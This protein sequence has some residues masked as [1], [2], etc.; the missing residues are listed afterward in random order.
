[1]R[2][3]LALLPLVALSG[4]SKVISPV[5]KVGLDPDPVDKLRL[6]GL[7]IVL[8]APAFVI[9]EKPSDSGPMS[10]TLSVVNRPDPVHAYLVDIKP[11][12]MSTSDYSLTYGP[13]GQVAAIGITQT[14]AASSLIKPIGDFVAGAVSIVAKVVGA[15]AMADPA[16]P[17]LKHGLRD[18]LDEGAH[19]PDA[20]Y[21]ETAVKEFKGPKPLLELAQKAVKRCD[22]DALAAL[23]CPECKKLLGAAEGQVRCNAV[24][25]VKAR[26]RPDLDDAQNAAL[27][28][29]QSSGE[30][31]LFLAAAGA[32]AGFNPDP[33]QQ[34]LGTADAGVAQAV[35]KAVEA[36]MPDA[37][38]AVVCSNCDKL[39]KLA[40]EVIAQRQFD[41]PLTAAAKVSPT[42]WRNRHAARLEWNID[43]VE[44]QLAL[45]PPAD[46]DRKLR[47]Q[48]EALQN[49]LATT[50]GASD[51][52]ARMRVL[53]AVLER[54]PEDII[55]K[56]SKASNVAGMTEF[57]I[58]SKELDALA[59][60][61]AA[62]RQ[63][64]KLAPP[65]APPKPVERTFSVT[66]SWKKGG[67]ADAA[68]AKREADQHGKPDFIVTVEEG[69]QP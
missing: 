29:P 1:M 4:C 65:P 24:P 45:G 44:E 38:A 21:Y 27:L 40:T 13:Q 68:Y 20:S 14:S 32:A 56:L 55:P 54:K 26:L 42:E 28:Y 67:P 17:L 8:T 46:E 15:A 58:A 30:R 69:T 49:Q 53:Q 64:L 2:S 59:T 11:E 25:N 10:Y 31:Q 66:A 51:E 7:P 41:K 52:L 50:I 35:K 37:V 6:S 9:T 57:D 39:K 34:A 60:V 33:L 48:R 43:R 16:A 61:M 47:A 36:R 3:A 62:K 63:A 23:S 12:K 5:G 22:F 18:F 19:C